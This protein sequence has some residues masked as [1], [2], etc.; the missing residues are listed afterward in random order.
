MLATD[1]LIVGAN[2]YLGQYLAAS[3]RGARC[4]LH[5]ASS[6]TPACA[7]TGLP[8][9][10]EDLCQSWELLGRLNPSTVYLLARPVTQKADV[11]LKFGLNVQAMLQEW[12]GR[13]C[14]KRVVFA[15]TQLVYAT[16]PDDKPIDV[17]F[18]LAPETPYDFHK[19]AMEF[20]LQLLARHPAQPRVEIYRLPL[21]AGRKPAGAQPRPQFIYSWR[22]A[23]AR[24]DSWAFPDASAAAIRWGTSWAHVDDVVERM[25]REAPPGKGPCDLVQPVSGSFTY[26]EMH[27][28]LCKR[29][30][31][32]RSAQS[33]HLPKTCFFLKDN[34]KLP[35]RGLEEALEDR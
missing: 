26:W 31:P 10:R 21:L 25:T 19:T 8:F 20:H 1:E 23:Y 18:P 27:Q 34:A 17:D 16:P 14:L 13:G 15:S 28:H 7:A 30:G 4:I 22:D 12:A 29:F 9:V 11:L 24:G 6:P 5:S 32:D 3:R 35:A 2:G 33:L